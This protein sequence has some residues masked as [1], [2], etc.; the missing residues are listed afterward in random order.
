MSPLWGQY[1]LEA[2]DP[3]AA[4]VSLARSPPCWAG[5]ER[6]F[7]LSADRTLVVKELSSE[8][9]ADVHALLSHYHQV[10]ARREGAAG[11]S[12][13]VL[14]VTL[15]V[16]SPRRRGSTWCSATAARCCRASWACTA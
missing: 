8:A 9:V 13:R 1:H 12:R 7:L 6:R 2:P 5:G 11:G 3:P 16:S 4:Q 15:C 14:G 10:P